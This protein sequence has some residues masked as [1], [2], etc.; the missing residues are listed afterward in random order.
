MARQQK[1]WKI[2]EIIKTFHIDESFIR[3]LE[4]DEIVCSTCK[5]K[6]ADKLFSPEDVEKLRLAKVLMEEMEVNRPGIEVILRMR[7]NMIDM[8]KQFDDILE[9]LARQVLKELRERR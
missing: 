1:H 3:E 5:K 2:T 4:E 7:Q 8:R 9:D 6:N